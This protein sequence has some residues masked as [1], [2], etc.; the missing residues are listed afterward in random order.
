LGVD[1]RIC[2]D[3]GVDTAKSSATMGFSLP[4]DRMPAAYR[5]ETIEV[6]KLSLGT[7]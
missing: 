5:H 2:I 1:P 4:S 6:R 7:S 3:P